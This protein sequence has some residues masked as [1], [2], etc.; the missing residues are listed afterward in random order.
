MTHYLDQAQHQHVR[1]LVRDALRWK[2]WRTWLL[3]LAVYGAWLMALYCREQLGTVISTVILIFCCVWYTSLQHELLHGHPT[4]IP[5]LNKLIGYAPLAVWYPYTLYRDSHLRHHQDD[6]LTYPGLDPESHYITPD[7]WQ[8]SG[9]VLRMLYRLRKTFWGR[10]AIGPLMAIGSML[11][12]EAC[13]MARGDFRY[14]P[15]WACHG[16]WLAVMLY[17][18][19][20]WSAIPWWQYLGCIAYPALAIAMIRSHFEHRASAK[21]EHRIVINEAGAFMRLLF[22][23]NNYHLVHHDLPHLPWYLIGVV[24][25]DNRDAYLCRCNGFLLQGYGDVVR[26]YGFKPVDEPPHPLVPRGSMR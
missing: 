1:E 10:M 20:R 8:G 23:N 3:I 19:Q 13:K 25:R 17:A 14:A 4:R 18:V 9:P 21:P 22:L 7:Q 12:E 5:W 2:E 26:R 24:Y 6:D 16:A 15:M 11:Q